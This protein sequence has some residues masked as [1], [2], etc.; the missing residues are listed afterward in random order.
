MIFPPVKIIIN[1]L[2]SFLFFEKNKLIN[3][4]LP[5][6]DLFGTIF[7]NLLANSHVGIEMM[8]R[9]FH[10]PY[11]NNVSLQEKKRTLLVNIK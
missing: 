5:L 3:N 11:N 4:V 9:F 6:A 2:N 8:L 7:W 1:K 10:K